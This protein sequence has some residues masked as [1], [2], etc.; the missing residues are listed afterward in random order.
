MQNRTMSETDRHGLW[1]LVDRESLFLPFAQFPW[2]EKAPLNAVMR[3]VR[4]SIGH[5]YWPDLDVDLTVDSIR[6]PERFPLIA[7]SGM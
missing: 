7:R 2:F 1:L 6:H 4:P 5:L 3:V